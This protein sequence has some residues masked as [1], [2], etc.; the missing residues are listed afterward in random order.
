M[1]LYI[2]TCP[3]MHTDILGVFDTKKAAIDYIK[4]Q[5]DYDDIAY[6]LY[7]YT[8]NEPGSQIELYY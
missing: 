5:G 1:I 8:L 3:E 2:V 4:T 7:A 6:F